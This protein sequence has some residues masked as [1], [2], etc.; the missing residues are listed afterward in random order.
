MLFKCWIFHIR[1]Q[2]GLRVVRMWKLITVTKSLSVL[3][4]FYF[5][6]WHLTKNHAQQLLR[7]FEPAFSRKTS[8]WTERGSRS[9]GKVEG[10]EKYPQIGHYP[11]CL[12]LLVNGIITSWLSAATLGKFHAFFFL[13]ISICPKSKWFWPSALLHQ[14]LRFLRKAT[15]RA[16]E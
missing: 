3:V 7:G 15:E 6:T 14:L 9:R 12:L 5:T 2:P 4:F 16:I 11:Y 10:L 8:F 13:L 1:M